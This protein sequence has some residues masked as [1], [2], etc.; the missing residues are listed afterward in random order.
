MEPQRF[1]QGSVGENKG[2]QGDQN[3][4]Y[5]D[6]TLYSMFSFNLTFDPLL[7]RPMDVQDVN[8]FQE[9]QTILREKIVNPLRQ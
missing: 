9:I 4:C 5:L 7:S 6:V 3:S 2:I 8:D 1:H